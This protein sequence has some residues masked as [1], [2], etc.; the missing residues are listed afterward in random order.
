MVRIVFIADTHMTPDWDAS[1]INLWIAADM[2]RAARA[3]RLVHLGDVGFTDLQAADL[4]LAKAVCEGFDAPLRVVPGNHDVGEP[5][6][7]EALARGD[8]TGQ[9][10][11]T[12]ENAHAFYDVFHPLPMREDLGDTT[13]LLIDGQ[14]L[15]SGSEFEDATMALVAEIPRMPARTILIAAHKTL[16][17]VRPELDRPGWTLTNAV[18]EQ[19]LAALGLRRPDQRIYFFSG[20]FHRWQRYRCEGIEFVW[21]P[22]LS[23]ITPHRSLTD[24]GGSPVPGF[25]EVEIEPEAL[26]KISMRSTLS[27]PVLD[28]STW[29]DGGPDIKPEV[30]RAAATQRAFADDWRA[31]NANGAEQG[32]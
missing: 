7:P 25:V 11:A 13:L 27:M 9:P 2:I 18:S 22:A 19:I 5:A 15:G 4:R 21:V 30:L 17:I 14:Q 28:I 24:R 32:S 16:G 12:L 6:T 3:D 10:L 29:V 1:S 20:H 26:P 8:L 23:F 31:R